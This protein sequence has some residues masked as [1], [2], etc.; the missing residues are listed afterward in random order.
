ME[1]AVIGPSSGRSE[2]G[3]E[4]LQNHTV[5]LCHQL[6]RVRAI[7]T[8]RIDVLLT[9]A[10]EIVTVCF[11]L[12]A[13][14]RCQNGDIHEILII[15][16]AVFRL[17]IRKMQLCDA[18]RSS[19]LTDTSNGGITSRV[20]EDMMIDDDDLIPRNASAKTAPPRLSPSQIRVSQITAPITNS[21]Q[22]DLVP[23]SVGNYQITKSE[24]TVIT[25]VL[26]KG[27][28]QRLGEVITAFK[29]RILN[30][31]F[32]PPNVDHIGD[33][34][35]EPIVP[36]DENNSDGDSDTDNYDEDR[37][38]AEELGDLAQLTCILQSL[39]EAVH[40]MTSLGG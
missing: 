15:I 28:L 16:I 24:L 39:E 23:V 31:S 36:D 17:L 37:T 40:N 12:L 29:R 32:N 26:R 38:N 13:C 4:C 18:K 27:M 25:D 30:R 21:M 35:A 22:P 6:G 7:T 1:G 19:P 14:S 8:P 10:R 3:Q 5:A 11:S 20:N 9:C 2:D 33:I 34:N